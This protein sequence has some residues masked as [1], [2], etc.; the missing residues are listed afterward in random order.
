MPIKIYNELVRDQLVTQARMRG[1]AIQYHF[2]EDDDE[3]LALLVDK[4]VASASELRES[5]SVEKLADVL[6]VVMA[7]SEQLTIPEHL[8]AVREMKAGIRGS[9]SRRIYLESIEEP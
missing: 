6:E 4:L 1:L 7:I 9:F 5:L 2:I 8:Q 3:Y